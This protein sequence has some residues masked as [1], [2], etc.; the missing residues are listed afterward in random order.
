M[1][2][3]NFNQ[4]LGFQ[5]LNAKEKYL[6]AKI[7]FGLAIVASDN[8]FLYFSKEVEK[9]VGGDGGQNSFELY[10]LSTLHFLFPW[11]NLKVGA[12]LLIPS[13]QKVYTTSFLKLDKCTR[14]GYETM[15]RTE[16]RFK[17]R[18]V[19]RVRSAAPKGSSSPLDL[20]NIS[21]EPFIWIDWVLQ[22]V[23]TRKTCRK[24]STLR[25]IL[26]VIILDSASLLL[27]SNEVRQNKVT[28]KSSLSEYEGSIFINCAIPVAVHISSSRKAG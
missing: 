14:R 3:I 7:K 13:S 17:G 27:L 24:L 12:C 16:S 4:R 26:R 2:R 28:T 23:G 6:S 21:Y 1:R 8:F 10:K 19:E 5:L 25:Q 9:T 15:E 11:S 20:I 18:D 22:R